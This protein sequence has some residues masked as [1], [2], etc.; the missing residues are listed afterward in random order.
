MTFVLNPLHFPELSNTVAPFA[1]GYSPLSPERFPGLGEGVQGT[2]QLLQGPHLEPLSHCMMSNLLLVFREDVLHHQGPLNDWR[3]ALYDFCLRV[4]FEATFMTVY[5]RSPRLRDI[6]ASRKYD[7]TS[8][9]FL[10]DLPPVLQVP[11]WL[12]GRTEA[13]RQRLI[14]S[15]SPSL[16]SKWSNASLFIQR[17]C[18]LFDQQEALSSHDKAGTALSVI[19]IIGFITRFPRNLFSCTCFPDSAVSES[20]RLS[21]MSINVRVATDDFTLTLDRPWSS[22]HL[23][24][25]I[26]PD[27]ESF[28]FDR[29]LDD[30]GKERTDFF[31][32]GQRLKHFLM[33]FGSG[34]TMCPGRHIARQEIKQFV[35]LLLLHLDLQLDEQEP[36][37]T[38]GLQ[39][40][41]PRHHAAAQR[42]ALQLQSA[43]P[44]H[45][46]LAKFKLGATAPPIG[47][48]W[49]VQIL[50]LRKLK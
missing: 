32:G 41:R 35:C 38:A 42:R 5:G 20:L 16:V 40:R 10:K 2:F 28:H 1:F 23:D 12:L 44:K 7:R 11:L 48:I 27:P 46:H 13:V 22:V 6:A 18:E 36:P 4:A 19:T 17:R 21:T 31:K 50:V 47:I 30:D 26:Y 14:S 49:R 15:F 45:F 43:A 33:P 3:I 25:E 37:A 9:C 39:P 8:S 34:A 24:P 29:F